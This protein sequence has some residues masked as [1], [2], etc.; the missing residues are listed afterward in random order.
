MNIFDIVVARNI[1]YYWEQNTKDRAPYPG[2]LLFP[3]RKQVGLEFSTLKGKQG[4]PV[5]LVPSTFDANVLYRDFAGLVEVKGKLPFFKEAQKIEED[6]R[7]K[8]LT[9]NE[10][11]ANALLPE[12]FNIPSA[13]LDGAEVSIEIMRMQLL[14]QGTIAMQGAN[15]VSFSYDYGFDTN[16]QLVTETTTWDA[17]SATPFKSLLKQLKNFKKV[18]KA[19]PALVFI[20]DTKFDQ[21]L[22]DTTVAGYFAQSNNPA[23]SDDEVRNYIEKK[24]GVRF[25]VLDQVYKKARDFNGADVRFYPEDRYTIVPNT[26]LGESLYGTTPE[27]A[28]LL[29][30]QSQASSCE[31]TSKGVAV[32]TWREVDPV[33][34]NVKV[35]QVCAPTCPNID[36]IYIVKGI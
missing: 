24:A 29:G 6:L 27:E 11:F 35:S 36:K 25:V 10:K 12:V 8:L 5:A 17:T 34:V 26:Y 28:D 14:S 30:K 7:Q 20:S 3:S 33:N 15:G 2:E 1:L 23:P 16:T 9:Y 4:T 18:T 21:L 19:T 13:L 32:T 22:L 31:L